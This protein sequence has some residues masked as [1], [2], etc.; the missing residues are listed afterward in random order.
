M[1]EIWNL[2]AECSKRTLIHPGIDKLFCLIRVFP[3]EVDSHFVDLTREGE[4][5][6]LIVVVRHRR[7]VI[8]ADIERLAEREPPGMV[9]SMAPSATFLPFTYSSPV[10]FSI[11][12]LMKLNF[13]STFPV[14]KTGD[15]ME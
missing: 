9:L 3:S 8:D 10:P 15:T 7:S 14:G 6:F 2:G 11:P 12:V 13:K 4:M 5:V 1:L